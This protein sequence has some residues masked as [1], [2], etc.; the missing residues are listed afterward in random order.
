ML[1]FAIVVLSI[2]AAMPGAVAQAQDSSNEA[3]FPAEVIR[4]DFKHLYETLRAAHFDLYAYRS[5]E[6]YEDFYEEILASIDAPMNRAEVVRL[7]T[8][9]V[10]FGQIGH[11]R[12]DFPVQDYIEYALAGGTLLPLDI[13]VED[14]RTFITHNY[15]GVPALAP[16]TELVS[17]N[18]RDAADWVERIGR[19]VS[20]ERPYMTH[21]QLESMFPRLVWLEAGAFEVFDVTV[22]QGDGDETTITVDAVP[23]ISVEEQKGSRE[24][25]QHSRKAE[26]LADGIAYLRPGP[27]YATAE[28]E[29][30]ETFE[31]Y[32]DAAFRGFVASGAQDLVIDLRHNP[33]GDNSFSDPMIAWIAD[34]PFRFA[35]KF[36]VKASAR[37]REVLRGL[38]EQY[39]GGISAQMLEAMKQ[40]E[41]GD[42]FAFEIPQVQPRDSTFSGRT[43]VLVNRHS[44]SNATSAAAII[45]DYGF[46]TLLGEETSDLPTS[47]A[48]S[49]QFTLPETGI[50]VTY[51]KAYF[52]RPSGDEA[53]RGVVPDHALDFPVVPAEEDVVLRDALRLVLAERP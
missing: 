8:P 2:A 12:I 45:Q 32:I 13:R 3:T 49:A 10:S 46:G 48:S 34:K 30:L 35:S 31:A 39:P 23:V 22:R 29:T 26:M 19:L 20:A 6:A 11:A 25:L 18:G 21:A 47:Y 43:W 51:P 17:I 24:A 36:V 52:V 33:G 44:Y 27:F 5:R 28:G 42:T 16:E 14:G 9:F 40:H 53:L 41:D 37:T 50:V 1:T 7:F 38:A 4:E 15:S